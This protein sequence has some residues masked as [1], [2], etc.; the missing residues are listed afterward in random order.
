V[1]RQILRMVAGTAIAGAGVLAF[2]APAQ[3][4]ISWGNSGFL[5]GNQVSN[6][7]QVPISVC[8][9]AIAVFGFA[10]AS[11]QGGAY[12][13]NYNSYRIRNNGGGGPAS[14]IFSRT[15]S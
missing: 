3:A 11:C 1:K 2:A 9:N 15:L 8:G 5:S 10:S 7:T 6:V 4:Q 14:W 13:V 12:A